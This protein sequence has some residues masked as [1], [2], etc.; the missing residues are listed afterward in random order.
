[1]LNN[2]EM[3][4]EWGRGCIWELSEQFLSKPKIS[5]KIKV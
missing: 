4:A 1:M 5:L 2:K 3:Y